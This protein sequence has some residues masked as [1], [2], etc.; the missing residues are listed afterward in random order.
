MENRPLSTIIIR[1]LIFETLS[2][3]EFCRHHSGGYDFWNAGGG[4]QYNLFRLVEIRAIDKNLIVK[5]L[6]VPKSA[7]GVHGENLFEDSNTNFNKTEI[8][9]F[10][11]AFYLLLNTNIIA[12]GMY[13]NSPELPFFH[14][15]SHGEECIRAKDVLP[16]D[17]DGYL[18]KLKEIAH[19]DEWVEFYVVEA[20]RCYNAG[21]YN[22]A[23][24]M[25]GLS[26]EYLIESLLDEFS[27]LLRKSSLNI[28][29]KPSLQISHTKTLHQYYEE[30]TM[31]SIKISTRYEFFNEQ[32]LPNLK[33]LPAEIT[34]L[35]DKPSRKSF[36]D[37]LR[38]LRNEVSHPNEV[39][40][41]STE[42]LL[43]LMGYVK[44][45]SLITTVINS[46]KQHNK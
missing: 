36:G 28:H 13:G 14:V 23:T 46:I 4:T 10:W 29:T 24:M 39:K 12:P 21:C 34:N 17:I 27:K 35:L 32:L 41:E 9:R 37:Y 43:L 38:L 18:K 40:R 3:R 2:D 19:L 7:W 11:E 16:Y 6:N 45:C 30:R 1:D 8:E 42:T 15:T 26:S 44:Y 5:K 20:L 31:K 33:N 25:I 22:S